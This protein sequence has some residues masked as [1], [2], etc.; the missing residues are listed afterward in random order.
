[1]CIRDRYQRRVRGLKNI[2]ACPYFLVWMR[3][4]LFLVLYPLG[5]ASEMGLMYVSL[6]HIK[7][8]GLWSIR[9]PNAA[10]MSFDLYTIIILELII[11]VPGLYT[12]YTYMLAQR[13]KVL[14][15]ASQVEGRKKV[16]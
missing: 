10:N 4:T 8:T 9:M 11:W 6:P 12:M 13:K 16:D 7:Q 3:Y 15:P 1:M 2:D 14:A 5:V